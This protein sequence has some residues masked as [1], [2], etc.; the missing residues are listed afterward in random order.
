MSVT[1]L[2]TNEQ[3]RN[4]FV[5]SNSEALRTTIGLGGLAAVLGASMSNKS[6]GAYSKPKDGKFR[7]TKLGEAGQLLKKSVDTSFD[8][9]ASS[10][11]RSANDFFDDL[12]S[13]SSRILK[14]TVENSLEDLP[15]EKFAREKLSSAIKNEK[16][17]L[18]TAVRDSIRDLGLAGE[19]G[20]SELLLGK[21][22]DILES[23]LRSADLLS[24]EVED[25]LR[26]LR[27]NTPND[28][29]I[30]QYKRFKS[31]KDNQRFFSG[32]QKAMN[33]SESMIRSK[34]KI[35]NFSDAF[36]QAIMLGENIGEDRID[37]VL[38]KRTSQFS[39]LEK[40]LGSFREKLTRSGGA[41]DGFQVIK[42]HD[43]SMASIY[44]NVKGRQRQLGFK[45]ALHL[46]NVNNARKIVRLTNSL[47]TPANISSF[48]IDMSDVNQIFSGQTNARDV[49]NLLRKSTPEKYMQN[50]FLRYLE[51]NSLMIDDV[52]ER[53]MNKLLEQYRAQTISINR[54]SLYPMT[55]NPV[56][57]ALAKNLAFQQSI[58]SNQ[59]I[60]YGYEGSK[61]EAQNVP[62]KL[63]GMYPEVFDAPGSASA[64]IRESN[65]KG[66]GTQ[67]G[68]NVNVRKMGD[69]TLATTLNTL[70]G[71]GFKN[72]STT[73]LTS[74]EYQF[75]GRE[76]LLS[77]IVFD[78][79]RIY[80]NNMGGNVFGRGKGKN[81]IS[82]MATNNA[83]LSIDRG[84]V[85]T[86]NNVKGAGLGQVKGANFAGI[87]FFGGG[88][89]AA[90]AG[91]GEGQAYYGGSMEVEIPLQKS[92]LDP[93]SM[94]RP[95]FAFLR[96]LIEK[97]GQG[98][99]SFKI[100]AD[101]IPAIF[102]KYSNEM[103]EIPLGEID[104][105]IVGLKRYKGLTELEIQIDPLEGV[106]EDKGRVKYNLTGKARMKSD[107]TKLFGILGRTTSIGAP[108]TEQ[109]TT[110]A[111]QQSFG[112]SFGEAEGRLLAQGMMST[113]KQEFGG[114]MANL[115]IGDSSGIVKGVDYLQN[116][117]YG[118]YRMLGG[119]DDAL[120]KTGLFGESKAAKEAVLN[121]SKSI[122]G[123]G[124]LGT[125]EQMHRAKL[126]DFSKKLAQSLIDSGEKVSSTA[127]TAML[128]PIQ[129]L[130]GD[131]FNLESGDLKKYVTDPLGIDL[132]ENV[133]KTRIA[134]GAGSG[135][136]GSAPQILGRNMAKFEPRHAN[137][138]M[139]GMRTFFGLNTE[140]SVKY[141]NDFIIRQ[142]GVEYSGKFLP[143]IVSMGVGLRS[144]MR[145]SIDDKAFAEM[146]PEQFKSLALDAQTNTKLNPVNA[147]KF[148]RNL[149]G[150]I[151]Y[152]RPT[153]LRIS[154]V[155]KEKRSLD[156]LSN[157][158]PSGQVV[159]P[160][161]RTLEGMVNY[162]IPKGDSVENIDARLVANLKGMFD[163]LYEI[164]SDVKPSR[165]ANALNT[166]VEDTIDASSLALR[167]SISGSVMGSISAQGGALILDPKSKSVTLADAD[168]SN[169]RRVYAKNKGYAVFGNTGLFI[170]SL[171]S[172]MGAST[173]SNV[174]KDGTDALSE[175]NARSKMVN[176]FKSFMFE[177]LDHSLEP[178]RGP[179]LRNPSMSVTHM[180]PGIS[181]NRF[182][183][184][185]KY[186]VG[187]M[188]D[189]DI[190]GSISN[191]RKAAGMKG[192]MKSLTPE[193]IFKLEQKV[194][195]DEKIVQQASQQNFNTNIEEFKKGMNSFFGTN[196]PK[197]M[198]QD[199]KSLEDVQSNLNKIKDMR[200]KDTSGGLERMESS[201]RK[202]RASLRDPTKSTKGVFEGAY[203]NIIQKFH[204][205]QGVGGNEIMI[206]Q[207]EGEVKIKGRDKVMSSRLDLAYSLI[208]DFDADIYQFFHETKNISQKAFAERGED[209]I[210]NISRASA[211]FGVIRNLI[212]ESYKT[213]GNKLSSD[214]MMFNKFIA[215]Q[216]KKEVILKNV[217]GVDVQFKSVLLG[218]VENS[219]QKTPEQRQLTRESA[220]VLEQISHSL[221]T[222]GVYQDTSTIKAK[223]LPF[224]VEL[225]NIIGGAIRTG[226]EKGD[227]TEFEDVFKRL[228]L[229]N[230][231]ELLEG[232]EIEDVKLKGG[233]EEVESMYQKN[234]RGQR[235]SGLEI[236]KQFS[237]G[238]KTAHR[239]GLYYM[240]S[241]NKL[242]K[243]LKALGGKFKGVFESILMR[244][245]TMEMGL[246]GT[247][248]NF[249]DSGSAFDK[250]SLAL[251][252]LSS[253]LS[254]AKSNVMKS[255]GGKGMAGLIG[256]G[257]V[258]SY[259]LGATY[260]TSA[261]SSPDKF[262]DM[263]VKN[264]IGE[265]AI[266]NS[267]SR[268]HR[269]ISPQ[270]MQAPHNLYERQIMQKQMYVNKPSSIA[271]TGNA[272]NINEAQQVLQ[273]IS[274]MGGRGHLSIQDNVMP[275]PNIAD[276]YMR[277]Y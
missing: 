33:V 71:F 151:D 183:V 97:R 166:L 259:A 232:F 272:S 147:D 47:N 248:S 83:L 176:K 252:D 253:S 200:S 230:S 256:A 157:I 194:M 215:D 263:K 129:Y 198:I 102:S 142:Q 155:V 216:A 140:Q 251:E 163:H 124:F 210:E 197:D 67:Y 58:N 93:D 72:R 265:R 192:D 101:Q 105:R 39:Y 190:K 109:Q 269:D 209:I 268:Q 18:L 131:K 156:L 110:K 37:D 227:V 23:E 21:I 199:P 229:N 158:I 277:D 20:A 222:G 162:Q 75:F 195:G 89:Q 133:L 40:Q 2:L 186:Q 15:E 4:E 95:E 136:A 17:Y 106:S 120:S 250:T 122:E 134:I 219:L 165:R 220:S 38:K 19:K 185:A 172:F 104:N 7:T 114:K 108:I 128:A 161:G 244:R 59:A 107:I 170:D 214:G 96:N 267:T 274:S 76:D 184:S 211:K 6:K 153:T 275:R 241:E 77:G 44:M 90:L 52:S 226:L 160:S 132:D 99:K 28:K 144:N 41:V 182:D 84:L 202:S 45:P 56:G 94:K 74:R 171:S 205:T 143:D 115:I 121:L 68:I 49:E 98:K 82:I 260:S 32:K 141:L 127:L 193:D 36:K 35:G 50:T 212:D 62:V 91:L 270:S 249:K 70:R 254:S 149:I 116:Y 73:P 5:S 206:P 264:Q 175:R 245:N 237:E 207:F 179:L 201:L 247:P 25:V 225:G 11:L 64:V 85:D 66:L 217:G 113:Y 266:Y 152:D 150:A 196:I 125:E 168:L 80:E 135:F 189:E 148:R 43:G 145:K 57:D 13:E 262:S 239:E 24:E 203:L 42:E 63:M 139:Y 117:M 164:D 231:P 188:L 81:K 126:L 100:K 240:G 3:N 276:Y 181:L 112:S 46:S 92:V 26:T 1:N 174:I 234:L 271:I 178:S 218:M 138:L 236:M 257:L 123:K 34:D 53:E 255:F 137:I 9:R 238:I 14:K 187:D 51:S 111:I 61:R 180:L 235:I 118:G 30:E 86:L 242:S 261:L 208:G 204:N 22:D 60:I 16:T 65:L 130:E 173:K 273:S 258:S 48:M 233:L 159:I 54:G 119:T 228:I 191:L 8:N 213:L 55:N 27:N 246:L 221:V 154:D 243:P 31:L 146:T 223:K 10:S 224:A 167:K 29:K 177:H 78:G 103:G 87:T 169:A 69:Q 88:E 79:N 12:I